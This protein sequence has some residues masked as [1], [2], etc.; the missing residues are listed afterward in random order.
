MSI[1]LNDTQLVLLSAA[2]QRED[3]L[4]SLPRG[5]KLAQAKRAAAKLLEKGLVHE[6]KARK[7]SP[8]WRSDEETGQAC[9]LKLTVAGTKAIAVNESEKDELA[10]KAEHASASSSGQGSE[11]TQTSGDEHSAPGHSGSSA[12][13]SAPRS[14]SKIAGVIA[15]L[16][17]DTGATID[18]LV[19]ATGWL[20][21]TTR[22]ALTGLRKRGF[23]MTTDR[24][25]KARGSVY[26]LSAVD[27]VGAV[28]PVVAAATPEAELSDPAETQQVA[29][30]LRQP[31]T[32]VR[33]VA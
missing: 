24:S 18:E 25:D 7:E 17:R 27:E 16:A 6:V 12:Q 15:M 14:G 8:I 19:A 29:Q 31:R 10:A 4:L 21:H 2:A 22:A 5:A 3:R 11:E 13:P 23:A 28:S 33:R 1:K 26:R 30:T 32:R 9:A 20:P